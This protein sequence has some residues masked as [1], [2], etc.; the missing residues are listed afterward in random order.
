MTSPVEMFL[1]AIDLLF[2]RISSSEEGQKLLSQCVAISGA[3]QQHATVYWSSAAPQ[4]L[5]SL[6]PE[7]TL[8]DQLQQA[9]SCP[10]SPNWQDSSTTMECQEME[11]SLPG[12]ADELAQRT[13]SRAHERFSGPQ[14]MKLRKQ[15]SDVY[16]AT[17]RISLVSSFLT[18]VLC[19]EGQVKGMEESDASGTNIWN[20]EQ[21]DWDQDL[22]EAVSGSA[23]AAQALREKLGSVER[24]GGVVAGDVGQYFV[25]RYGINQSK[26]AI[27]VLIQYSFTDLDFAKTLWST[28]SRATTT[29][30]SFLLPL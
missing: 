5:G 17:S 16:E 10:V 23:K 30:P 2:Q 6:S 27:S 9:F 15:K 29:L 28:T 14:I 11:V 26:L 4:L 22:L 25:K 24:D 21:Q 3:A 13:G 12:G 7:R 8:A 19:A 20:L 1:K 18:T